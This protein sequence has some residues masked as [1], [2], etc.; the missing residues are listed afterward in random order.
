MTGNAE[1]IPDP[2]RTITSRLP[3]TH[4]E[5]SPSLSNTTSAAGK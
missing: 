2:I 4:P 3:T 1:V 5:L